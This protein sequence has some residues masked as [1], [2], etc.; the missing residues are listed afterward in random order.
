MDQL[1]LAIHNTAHRTK[2]HAEYLAK[3]MGKSYQVFIN[4]C[5]YNNDT[6]HLNVAELRAMMVLSNDFQVLDVLE[7]DRPGH[8]TQSASLGDALLHL[9]VEIGDVYSAISTAKADGKVTERERNTISRE[10]AEVRA[11][12][13]DVEK[14]VSAL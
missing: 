7:A 3:A 9:G 12:L 10:I 13:L 4:K 6:H 14:L 2:D 1:D 8:E 5:N 11:A